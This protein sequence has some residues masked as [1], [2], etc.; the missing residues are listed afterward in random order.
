MSRLKVGDVEVEGDFSLAELEVVALSVLEKARKIIGLDH[1]VSLGFSNTE[2]SYQEGRVLSFPPDGSP[3]TPVQR[4]DFTPMAIPADVL[5][6]A[7]RRDAASEGPY[8]LSGNSL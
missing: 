6:R 7:K 3:A 2:V 8:F 5:E 4:K 1:G